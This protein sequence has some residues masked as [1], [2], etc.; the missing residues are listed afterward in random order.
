MCVCSHFDINCLRDRAE[1][2]IDKYYAT[3]H[4]G[5]HPIVSV[6]D[7]TCD[8]NNHWHDRWLLHG[9]NVSPTHP[10][11]KAI[12][13]DDTMRRR[14]ALFIDD[15]RKFVCGA[16]QFRIQIACVS[17]SLKNGFVVQT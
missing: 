13:L 17:P 7:T 11:D 2:L 5:D 10:C 12:L 1:P 15:L 8:L 16:T 14:H 6:G 4:E 3:T 9:K